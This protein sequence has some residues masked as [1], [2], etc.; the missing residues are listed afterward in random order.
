M[1]RSDVASHCPAFVLDVGGHAWCYI[2]L[3]LTVAQDSKWRYVVISCAETCQIGSGLVMFKDEASNRCNRACRSSK[4]EPHEDQYQRNPK[5]SN[6]K[7]GIRSPISGRDS[8]QPYLISEVDCGEAAAA[9]HDL[10]KR[11][12]RLRISLVYCTKRT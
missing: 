11:P 2:H 1:S 7:N 4:Y 3:P 6:D 5:K 9:H 12:R 10:T 8:C